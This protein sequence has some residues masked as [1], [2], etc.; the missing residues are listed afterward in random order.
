[1]N[2]GIL[3]AFQ[4]VL[5]EIVVLVEHRDLG[6]G[7]LGQEVGSVEAGLGLQV[8]LPAHRPRELGRVVEVGGAGGDEE[9]RH[10][11]LVE[12]GPD[13]HV[14]RR[15]QHVEDQRDLVVLDQL[16]RVLDRLGRRVAVVEADHL[17]YYGNEAAIVAAFTQFLQRV[18]PSGLIVACADSP[19]LS[20]II[21]I[22]QSVIVL[23]CQCSGCF[24]CI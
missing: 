6:V 7:L 3:D 11:L 24:V 12:V 9:L 4:I 18:R 17:E 15:A 1:M 8:G 5:A 19:H 22:Q 2:V 20:S 14:E 21:R 10:L 23:K 13:R 16:A